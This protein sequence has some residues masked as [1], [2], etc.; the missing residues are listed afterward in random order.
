MNT[1]KDGR[2]QGSTS[3]SGIKQD[4]LGQFYF[5]APDG[6]RVDTEPP[7]HFEIVNP[8]VQDPDPEM[9]ALGRY[10]GGFAGGLRLIA[11][12]GGKQHLV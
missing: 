3:L 9:R 6:A 8:V 4:E 11:T 12:V 7:V 2:W 1:Y 5:I 10:S